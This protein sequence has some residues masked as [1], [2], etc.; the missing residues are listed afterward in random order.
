[1]NPSQATQ[2]QAVDPSTSIPFPSPSLPCSVLLPPGTFILVTHV[3]G[4]GATVSLVSGL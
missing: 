1:M 3:G 2:L 4:T